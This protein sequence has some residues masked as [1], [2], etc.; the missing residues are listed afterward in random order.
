MIIDLKYIKDRCYMDGDCWIWRMGCTSN[1]TPTLHDG[2]KQYGA[3]RVVAALLGKDITG[4]CVTSSCGN[5]KC[6]C[7]DHV[8]VV[9]KKKMADLIVERTGHPYRVERNKKISDTKRKAGKLTA[10][11]AADI[12]ESDETLVAVALKYGIAKS[13]A[14]KIRSGLSWKTYGGFFAGLG[15]R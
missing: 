13:T 2:P 15:A 3:R 5:Q 9:N 1:K 11:K 4:K 6:V 7:P 10:E 14:Q 12:R 8:L